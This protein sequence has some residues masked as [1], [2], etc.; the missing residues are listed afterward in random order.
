MPFLLD[1]ID[2]VAGHIVSYFKI[3]AA[4]NSQLENAIKL[5]LGV[6]GCS[7]VEVCEAF[8]LILFWESHSLHSS[9]SAASYEIDTGLSEEGWKVAPQGPRGPPRSAPPIVRSYCHRSVE[10]YGCG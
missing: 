9:E 10:V 6:S 1:V 2:I 3:P 7:E 8:T 4:F 5:S